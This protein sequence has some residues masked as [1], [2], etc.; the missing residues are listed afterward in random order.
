[1]RLCLVHTELQTFLVTVRV[2]RGL[3]PRRDHRHRSRCAAWAW[4]LE[5]VQDGRVVKCPPACFLLKGQ[6][7]RK[8]WHRSGDSVTRVMLW[9]G[10]GGCGIYK[11]KWPHREIVNKVQV[12]RHSASLSC[13]GRCLWGQ[14]RLLLFSFSE[15]TWVTVIPT[16]K[17]LGRFCQKQPAYFI[18]KNDCKAA[19]ASWGW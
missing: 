2:S 5:P 9:G 16:R 17:S 6:R 1:M 18:R 12:W 10:G 14:K 7:F 13:H 19:K 4:G 11:A 8:R 15:C 3:S